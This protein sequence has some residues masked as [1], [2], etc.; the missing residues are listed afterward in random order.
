MLF[1]MACTPVLTRA[2]AERIAWEEVAEYAR[3]NYLSVTHFRL[4]QG[5]AMLGDPL[6]FSFVA[7]GTPR[8]TVIVF[9]DRFGGTEVSPLID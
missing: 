7:E 9:V 5:E 3:R 8:H 4:A 6:S 2:Q 1:A